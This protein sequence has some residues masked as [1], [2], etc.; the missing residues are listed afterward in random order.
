MK[1][2]LKFS[3]V[4]VTI[5]FHSMVSPLSAQSLSDALVNSYNNSGLLE[6]NR[7]LLR[8]A[9][10]NTVIASSALLPIVSWAANFSGNWTETEMVGGGTAVSSSD[11]V[12]RGTVGLNSSLTIF[13]GG[14]NKF[15]ADVTKQNVLAT[16]QGLI[17]LE[18]RVISSAVSAF[19]G[20]L[21]GIETVRLREKNYSV[22]EEELRAARDRYEVGEITRT[23]VA[24]A[25]ARLASSSSALS[26]AK[27]LLVQAEAIFKNS[28]G[29][30]PVNL[31]A[32]KEMPVL[33]KTINEAL[34]I[35][36][37]SH[38]ELR[39]LQ[40]Q[41]KASELTVKRIKASSK[42]KM[43]LNGDIGISDSDIQSDTLQASIGLRLS[44]TIYQG[45]SIKA[46]Q[47]QALANLQA[48]R[49][50]VHVQINAIEQKISS[51]FAMLEV[52]K[53]TRAALEKQIEAAEVAFNGVKEEA[54]L[55]AR[56]TLD[57]LN[58]EQE[59]LDAKSQF[60]NAIYDEYMAAYD[61]LSASGLLTVDNLNLPV[62]KYDPEEYYKSLINN[63]D[64]RF[65]DLKI[66]NL[67]KE[68]NEE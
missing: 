43:I 53:T 22:I 32:P 27:G 10:E 50:T 41:I 40:Y 38:P 66:L 51:S 21:E 34:S 15:A 19:M 56:T 13:D 64:K 47:R 5:L 4:I 30:L 46:K 7:A 17:S 12:W 28:V 59:L 35:A 14:T 44:G 63:Q 62:A 8:A 39:Q 37:S 42:A 61:V 55:G 49:S 54:S 45:G 20:V 1:A 3:I 68:L 2:N 24:L 18:Q 67:L 58:A 6:Q 36:T 9:D 65:Q 57:V 60:I 29:V 23:D 26:A 16:R 48:V 25:E 52:A 33:P 31:V 11:L